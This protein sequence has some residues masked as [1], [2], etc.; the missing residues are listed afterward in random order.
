VSPASGLRVL[1]GRAGFVAVVA[2]ALLAAPTGA[3][4]GS[5]VHGYTRRDGTYV[6][7]H[8][9][10]S[11]GSGTPRTPT[12]HPPATTTFGTTTKRSPAATGAFQR[13]H[14]C[15]STGKTS[16]ACPGYVI[17][18]ITPLKRGG[19]DSPWNMQWQTTEAAKQKDKWE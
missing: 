7:P 19:A 16:G 4:A 11:P 5:W 8:Y 14:P 6:S 13:S 9:R 15:P 17:D 10:R 12:Y 2:I 1:T 3:S 18:H